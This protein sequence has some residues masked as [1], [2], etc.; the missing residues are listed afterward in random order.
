[1]TREEFY[2]NYKLSR[3]I[4][5]SDLPWII[6]I[7]ATF[8]LFIICGQK[9][10]IFQSWFL[11]ILECFIWGV[12]FSILIGL[13]K[14][15]QTSKFH[16]NCPACQ[17]DLTQSV[18]MTIATGKCQKCGNSL[19][20]PDATINL[21]PYV[22][23]SKM[24]LIEFRKKISKLIWILLIFWFISFVIILLLTV[25][26][27]TVGGTMSILIV[28][29]LYLILLLESLQARKEG[30]ICP[31]CNNVLCHSRIEIAIKTDGCSRCGKR[32]FED[33]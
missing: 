28:A 26:F 3:K 1:M 6:F 11:T 7:L 29:G 16:L 21:P 8:I 9:G 13:S 22:T 23:K 27:K 4:S 18:A 10:W 19:F 20:E 25:S 17:S 24:Q 14:I 32:L 33:R 30:F 2:K 31:K 15:K 5:H 12:I